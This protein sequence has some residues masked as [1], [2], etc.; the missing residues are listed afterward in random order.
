MLHAGS[1][2]GDQEHEQQGE[3][4]TGQTGDDEPARRDRRP[5]GEQ[6]PLAPPLGEQPRGN[7]ECGHAAAVGGPDDADLCEGQPELA[8]PDRQ[9]HVEDV[10]ESVVD[11]VDAAGGGQHRAGARSHAPIIPERPGA[12]K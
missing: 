7:L 4:A 2:P 6:T 3:E 10:R 1:E 11:E 5:R 12:F 9:E 8:R